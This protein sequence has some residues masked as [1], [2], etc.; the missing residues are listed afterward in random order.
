MPRSCLLMIITTVSYKCCR[1]IEGH[2][3]QQL[4]VEMIFTLYKYSLHRHTSI[5]KI[6][7]H[8]LPSSVVTACGDGRQSN[9]LIIA[10]LIALGAETHTHAQTHQQKHTQTHTHTHI[11]TRT[12]KQT[13][14]LVLQTISILRNH[15]CAGQKFCWCLKIFNG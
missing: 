1:T 9:I 12:H 2:M 15:L 11:H 5:T 13:H 14:I 10:L 6:S 4:L 3:H 8:L 7:D